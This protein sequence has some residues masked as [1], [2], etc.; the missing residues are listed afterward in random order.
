MRAGVTNFQRVAVA[1]HLCWFDSS[2]LTLREE[3]APILRRRLTQLFRTPA[4]CLDSLTNT[5]L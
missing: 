5:Q 4:S 1:K 3:I 2:K